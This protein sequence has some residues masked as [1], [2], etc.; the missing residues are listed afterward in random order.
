MTLDSVISRVSSS[1][2]TPWCSSAA[3]IPAGKSG[4]ERFLTDR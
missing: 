4:T 3:A 2:G 1:G